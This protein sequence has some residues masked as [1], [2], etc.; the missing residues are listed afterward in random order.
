MTAKG[1]ESKIFSRKPE[2]LILMILL[3]GMNITQEQ[4][5]YEFYHQDGE[6]ADLLML[7]AS[8]KIRDLKPVSGII[9]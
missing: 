8:T 5:M 9:E 6:N 2:R 7:G 4:V 3:I 1:K